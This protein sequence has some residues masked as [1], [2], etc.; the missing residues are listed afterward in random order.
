MGG[1]QSGSECVLGCHFVSVVG[2]DCRTGQ[3]GIGT[4]AARKKIRDMAYV[5][6]Y[7]DTG[8]DMDTNKTPNPQNLEWVNAELQKLA[9]KAVGA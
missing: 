7:R 2:H 1:P 5:A 6:Y 3:N 8:L 9:A 4:K